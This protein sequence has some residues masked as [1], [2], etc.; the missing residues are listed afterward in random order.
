M[1]P[2]WCGIIGRSCR[3]ARLKRTLVGAPNKEGLTSRRGGAVVGPLMRVSCGAMFNDAAAALLL[4]IR[5]RATLIFTTMAS[6]SM[7]WSTFFVSRRGS[8][9]TGGL[10][11]RYRTDR[12]RTLRP[13]SIRPR[14][15]KRSPVRCNSLRT[16]RKTA[17]RVSATD[18]TE[19]EK[20]MKQDS[21]FPPGW[22]E[23][24]VQ[25]LIEHYEIPNRGT[26]SGGG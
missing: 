4:L 3:R 18:E 8:P 15:Y 16:A 6:P 21:G 9:R 19:K 25:R 11:Y 24:R 7:K 14:S 17:Y 10:A 20:E 12:C 1:A 2:L 26:G 23:A 13:R 5:R 22:D